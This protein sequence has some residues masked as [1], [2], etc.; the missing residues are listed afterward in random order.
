ML[1]EPPYTGTVVCPEGMAMLRGALWTYV[2]RPSIDCVVSTHFQSCL[3][4]WIQSN[5][6]FQLKLLLQPMLHVDLSSSASAS[7][8]STVRDFSINSPTS[9]NISSPTFASKYSFAYFKKLSV[10]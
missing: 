3:N 2:Q 8:C 6:F 1:N 7:V 5:W 9:S 10:E 4:L